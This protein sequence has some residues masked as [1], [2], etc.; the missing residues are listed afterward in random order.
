MVWATH[1]GAALHG[2][3]R[4]NRAW[5]LGVKDIQQVEDAIRLKGAVL[6]RPQYPSR[7]RHRERGGDIE[8]ICLDP[9]L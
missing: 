4:E 1:H 3:W 2:Q 6:A 8:L 7:G 5:D 9:D